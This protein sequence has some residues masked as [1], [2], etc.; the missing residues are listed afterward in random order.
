MDRIDMI[1]FNNISNREYDFNKE[2][3]VN[4]SK[5]Y[6]KL[7]ERKFIQ[8]CGCNDIIQWYKIIKMYYISNN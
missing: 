6:K 7:V 4:I 2:D 5:I 3:Y 8:D 1:I